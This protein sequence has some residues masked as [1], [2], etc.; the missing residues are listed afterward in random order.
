[1]NTIYYYCCLA[2][3]RI[4]QRVYVCL[5]KRKPVA[6]ERSYPGVRDIQS[7]LFCFVFFLSLLEAF[8]VQKHVDSNIVGNIVRDVE[9]L[10][11]ARKRGATALQRRP[12]G[13]RGKG[14]L[15]AGQGYQQKSKDEREK[16]VHGRVFEGCLANE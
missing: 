4:Y 7:V 10:H 16:R 11:E 3:Q 14:V 9:L 2:N 15:M 13:T 5:C 8:H 1:M 6:K 12:V